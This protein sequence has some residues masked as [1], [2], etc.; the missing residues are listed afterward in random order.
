MAENGLDQ[1]GLTLSREYSFLLRMT[2]NVLAS[3]TISRSPVL[4]WMRR[5]L[6][7]ILNEVSER[8]NLDSFDLV[9]RPQTGQFFRAVPST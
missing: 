8:L 6:T 3:L 1:R 7:S 5:T 9:N 2:D 4:P